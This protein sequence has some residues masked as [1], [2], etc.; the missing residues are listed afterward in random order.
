MRVEHLGLIKPEPVGVETDFMKPVPTLNPD[1][2]G[3]PEDT[4]VADPMSIDLE[5]LWNG[6]AQRNRA[7]FAELFRTVPSDTV[8]NFEQ[9]KVRS[10][11]TVAPAHTHATMQNYVPKS[12]VC[13]L[14]PGQSLERVRQ[15]LSEVRGHL[16]E[17]PL[18]FLIEEKGIWENADWRGLNP[19]LQ[20]Y[21]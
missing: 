11:R 3:L 12:R 18:E 4:L 9:Y 6:T 16:V 20:V 5:D 10:N 21:I 8:R 13:H 15:R 1:E 7:I 17:A 2:F 19:T 14:A